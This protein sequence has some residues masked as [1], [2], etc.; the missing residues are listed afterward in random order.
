MTTNRKHRRPHHPHAYAWMTP[1]DAVR[2]ALAAYYRAC[3]LADVEALDPDNAC[4]PAAARMT[5]AERLAESF[6]FR[7]LDHGHKAG[8]SEFPEG[9]DKYFAEAVSQVFIEYQV[10]SGNIPCAKLSTPK[11]GVQM[12]RIRPRGPSRR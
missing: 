1:T 12:T 2:L 10:T 4:S 8:H 6:E 11:S 3:R 9:L 7:V 5:F